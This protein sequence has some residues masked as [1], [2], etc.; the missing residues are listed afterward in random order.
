M[1]DYE[2]F[3]EF[4]GQ[5]AALE[6]SM[7]GT[8]DVAA[9]F[10]GELSSMRSTISDTGR[11]VRSLSRSM[12]SGLK[13]AFESVVFDGDRLSDALLGLGNSISKAA[14]N[15]AVSPVF[16]HLGGLLGRGVQD[17]MSSL[18]PFADGASFSQGRVVPF[19]SGG[20]VGG[21]TYFPMRGATGLMGEAGPEAI[22]PLRRGAN[23]KLGVATDGGTRPVN[24]VMNITT[25]D[26]AGFERSRSQIA[27]QMSRALSSARRNR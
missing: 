22:L 16:G 24:V 2:D 23:G 12:S 3:D 26:V 6:R 14:Y 9:A 19:A 17:A 13:G 7:S 10:E 15:T 5:V 25:P 20:I 11:E 1:T 18:L 8:V 4:I 21:P 27:A